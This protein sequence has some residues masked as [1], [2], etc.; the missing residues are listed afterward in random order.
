MYN[1]NSTKRQDGKELLGVKFLY[2]TGTNQCKYEVNSDKLA[3]ILLSPRTTT[4]KITLKR[5]T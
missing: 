4:K 5:Y 2:F 3:C 1:N